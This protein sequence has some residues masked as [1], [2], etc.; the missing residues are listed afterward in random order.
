MRHVRLAASPLLS[1]RVQRLLALKHEDAPA[2]T[3]NP[4]KAESKRGDEEFS[5][6]SG[7]CA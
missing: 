5:A 4:K 3:W 7:P 2:Q 1:S 6:A